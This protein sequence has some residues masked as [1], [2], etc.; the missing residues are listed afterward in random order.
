MTADATALD[1]HEQPSDHMRAVWKG[2]SKAQKEDLLKSGDVDDLSVPE[3]LAEFPEVGRIPAEKLRAAFSRLA[4]GD[5]STRIPQVDRDAVIHHHPLIPGKL[6]TSDK[7]QTETPL[8]MQHQAF[9]S[10]RA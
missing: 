2:Y 3:K 4:E 7:Q 8:L 5:P 6:K 1:A 10:F 9:S